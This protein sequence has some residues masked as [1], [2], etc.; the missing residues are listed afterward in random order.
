MLLFNYAGVIVISLFI[1]LV[2][3]SIK[4]VIITESNRIFVIVIISEMIGAIAN[5]L[6]AYAD[7]NGSLLYKPLLVIL[8]SIYYLSYI[9]RFFIFSVYFRELLKITNVRSFLFYLS[10]AF[11]SIVSILI[12]TSPITSIIYSLGENNFFAPGKYV[13]LIYLSNFITILL[14]LSYFMS[15]YRKINSKDKIGI[16]IALFIL[17]SCCVI[18]FMFIH[19]VISDIFFILEILVL[20]LMFE[21]PDGYFDKKINILNFQAFNDYISNILFKK[22][23]CSILSFEIRN[24]KQ[25]KEIYGATQIELALKEIGSYLESTYTV[26]NC[27]YLQKGKFALIRKNKNELSKAKKEIEERFTKPW[28]LKNNTKILISIILI[29]LEET[30]DFRTFNQLESCVHE[31]S[32]ELR[33]KTDN[34]IIINNKIIHNVVRKSEVLKVLTRALDNDDVLLYF[35][36]I[37]DAKSRKIVAAEALARLY[38]KDMGIIG[39]GEFISMAEENGLI[40]TLSEQILQKACKFIHNTDMDKC[41]LQWININLSPIQCQNKNLIDKINKII[42]VYNIDTKYIHFEITEESMIDKTILKSQIDKLIDSGFSISLDDFG[43]GFSNFYSIKAYDFEN[44][45]L[46]MSLVNDHH[47][48]PDNLL[49]GLIKIF[50][51]RNLS[52]TA[53]GIETDDMA[54]EFEEMGCNYLQGY[55]FSQPIPQGKLISLL[56]KQ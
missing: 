10:F 51:S 52:I 20:Y 13:I 40:E 12:L 17:I 8:N 46:D 56:E 3:Y 37:V 16:I 2:I 30:L 24:Y 28:T 53:E 55:L 7:N 43:T 31:A 1:F 19:Y 15:S 50:R 23:N 11:T 39:P 27:F 36:P 35:Q 26:K 6:S 33:H 41:G 44:I 47:K 21:N 38:D 9:W 29:D 22:K 54:N 4:P 49:P 45:K 18:D 48:N 25:I 32:H 34:E 5:I 42:D 14:S